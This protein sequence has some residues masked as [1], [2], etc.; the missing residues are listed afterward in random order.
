[1]VG[2]KLR[3]VSSRSGLGDVRDFCEH[4]NELV[5]QSNSCTIHALKHSL[6]HLKPIKF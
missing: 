4:G 6:Q 5:I 1:M 3:A 2:R